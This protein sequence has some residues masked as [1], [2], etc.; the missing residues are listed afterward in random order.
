MYY[1]CDNCKSFAIIIAI[2]NKLAISIAII[3][4]NAISDRNFLI[5]INFNRNPC[6]ETHH[7][8]VTFRALV[9]HY[10]GSDFSSQQ[11]AKV[12]QLDKNIHYRSESS[13][14]TTNVQSLSRFDQE[15]TNNTKLQY[16]FRK[17]N[18]NSFSSCISALDSEHN[19]NNLTF[20]NVIKRI[21]TILSKIQHASRY[22]SILSN[23][24]SFDMFKGRDRYK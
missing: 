21:T 24:S 22:A 7:G 5:A 15:F 20:D 6:I 13:M 9:N 3:K 18:C 23:G 8:C 17:I 4:R 1:D 2:I 16:L 12:E 11:L 10:S 14:P 19:I